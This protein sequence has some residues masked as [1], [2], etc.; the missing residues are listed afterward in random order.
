MITQTQSQNSDLTLIAVADVC[1][2]NAIESLS[3]FLSV[4]MYNVFTNWSSFSGK[5]Q[6]QSNNS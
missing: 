4:F 6:V 5:G 3:H 1:E 2:L